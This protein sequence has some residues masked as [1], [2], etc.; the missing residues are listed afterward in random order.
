[1]LRYLSRRGDN[2]N[3]GRQAELRLW[4]SPHAGTVRS[5]PQRRGQRLVRRIPGSSRRS[6]GSAAA[7]E[8]RLQ[9]IPAAP[10]F[11]PIRWLLQINLVRVQAGVAWHFG[12]DLVPTNSH[13]LTRLRGV[14]LSSCRITG[15]PVYLRGAST[16]GRKSD[17]RP[18]PP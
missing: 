12:I 15:R 8:E 9:L 7:L 16:G 18:R 3:T 11:S 6:R 17:E 5:A 14:S 2:V 13:G 1:M 4:G 10:I